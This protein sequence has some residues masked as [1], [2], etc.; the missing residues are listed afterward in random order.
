MIPQGDPHPST[1][2]PPRPRWAARLR[3]Y[4]ADHPRAFAL[5]AS[6]VVLVPLGAFGAAAFI[7]IDT[8]RSLWPLGVILALLLL[9]VCVILVALFT[10]TSASARAAERAGQS[11]KL[12]N[13][14]AGTD[15]AKLAE[16]WR[17]VR[18]GTLGPDPE[19]NRLGRIAVEQEIGRAKT[20][21][22]TVV[23]GLATALVNAFYCVNRFILLDGGSGPVVLILGMSAL[24]VAAACATPSMMKRRRLRAEAFRDAYDAAYGDGADEASDTA[25]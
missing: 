8:T 19:T 7:T 18:Q 2:R 22:A 5:R 1:P 17:L 3:T 12:T 15:P 9:M 6:G 23:L 14:P 10:V 20:V 24:I 11:I 25:A 4:R 13:L 21:L 16:A